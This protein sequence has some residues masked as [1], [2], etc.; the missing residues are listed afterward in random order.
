MKLLA[1]ESI[2]K[3]SMLLLSFLSSIAV[4]KIFGYIS[5][6]FHIFTRNVFFVVIWL[7]IWLVFNKYLLAKHDEIKVIVKIV[8]SATFTM[9]CVLGL[10]WSDAFGTDFDDKKAIIITAIGV[11]PLSYAIQNAFFTAVK[12]V[13]DN[14]EERQNGNKRR[15]FWISFSLLFISFVPKLMAYFPTIMAY[16]A[17]NQL[18]QITDRSY[19]THHP[20]IHTAFLKLCLDWGHLFSS[21]NVGDIIGLATYSILQML[22]VALCVA[23]VYSYMRSVGANRYLCYFYLGWMILI[24][25]NGLFAIAITKDTIFFALVLVS[26]VLLFDFY[27]DMNSFIKNRISIIKFLLMLSIT[28][29]F[30]NNAIYAWGL[31]ALISSIYLIKKKLFRACVVNVL[32]LVGYL[33]LNM[34]F[35]IIMNPW[36]ATYAR[37][38]LSVPAQQIAR[39]CEYHLDEIDS[40]DLEIIH[41]IWGQEIDSIPEYVPNCADRSKK[42]IKNDVNELKQLAK[43]WIDLGIKYPRDYVYAFLLKNKGF[44]DIG[45]ITYE[46]VYSYNLSYMQVGHPV[47]EDKEIEECVPGYYRHDKFQYLQEKYRQFIS[48]DGEMTNYPIVGMLKQPALYCWLL[49]YYPFVC[50]L[51]KRKKYIWPSIPLLGLLITLYLGP[52]VLIRYIYPIMVTIPVMYILAISAN[53]SD[54]LA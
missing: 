20:L 35:S 10:W 18:M 8:L 4:C 39:V 3:V 36:N 53:T 12:A 50:I 26:S 37:E 48:I 7:C 45:D 23:Y 6:E 44:W 25:T 34:I 42:A 49:V 17:T 21:E 13:R 28:L 15:S 52:C 27:R 54:D 40:D 16:D 33:V 9:L 14:T 41:S 11:I 1:K 31:Y 43:L 30:R 47:E 38:S 19:T 5:G 2:T 46:R 22:I 51:V 32:P 29:M 24:P